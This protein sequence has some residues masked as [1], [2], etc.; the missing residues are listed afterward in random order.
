MSQVKLLC[1]SCYSPLQQEEKYYCKNCLTEFDYY[2]FGDTKI[3]DLRQLKKN[4]CSCN[5]DGGT[6][7]NINL[8]DILSS[9]KSRTGV[10]ET[11]RLEAKIIKNQVRRGN[12]VLDIGCAEGPFA[13]LISKNNY[14][15]GLDQCPKRL[16]LN[17]E[18]A[19]GKGYS[20]LVIHSNDRLPFPD[21]E[22]DVTLSTEVIEHVLDTKNF[23][24][25][26]RRVLKENGK[27]IL[28][29]PNVASWKNRL[30]ILLGDGR[31]IKSNIRYPEQKLH[32]RFF[33][34]F[35]LRKFLEE[36]GFRIIQEFGVGFTYSRL[37]YWL[38]GSKIFNK[39]FRTFCN[40][41]L[42]IAGKRKD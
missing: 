38:V 32:I 33:S 20:L 23:V 10:S 15:V 37:D 40:N 14:I 29:T 13:D 25:K 2:R 30:S 1:S 39:I 16:F 28:S 7:C 35:S 17:E 8:N 22:F 6:E 12:K 41:I 21:G 42:V 11:D 36:S 18:T 9:I 3:V 26:I 27:L 34:F 5:R 31:F 24:G 4:V 19:A